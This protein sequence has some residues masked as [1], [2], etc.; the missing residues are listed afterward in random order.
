MGTG[1]VIG[2]VIVVLIVPFIGI[3]AVLSLYGVRRYISNAKQAEALNT[4][5]QLAKV[6]VMAFERDGALCPSAA[7]PVPVQVPH[8]TK[9]LSSPADWQSGE[10]VNTGFACLK[11]SMMSSQ[12]YQYD[13]KATATGFTVTAHGDL[14]GDG[15]ESTF[16]MAGRIDN[17][18]LVVSPAI[19][20]TNPDE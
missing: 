1:A 9:Y 3:M 13:Y 5:G 18:T 10:S 11:F 17:G 19:A 12:Y 16:E 6:A 7:S 2:L 20:E 14:D 4:V 15:E 8:A